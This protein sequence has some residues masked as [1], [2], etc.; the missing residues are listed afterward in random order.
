MWMILFIDAL[1]GNEREKTNMMN[2]VPWERK[3]T[4]SEW[5]IYVA[6]CE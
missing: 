5:R 4:L 6:T 3:K 1:G 2:S